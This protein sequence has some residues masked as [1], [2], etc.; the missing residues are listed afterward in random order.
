MN[1]FHDEFQVYED[2]HDNS[3]YNFNHDFNDELV[4]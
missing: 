3:K 1:K 4:P 2:F